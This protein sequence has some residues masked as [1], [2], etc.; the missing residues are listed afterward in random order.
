VRK[1]KKL[2]KRMAVPQ[3]PECAPQ[4]KKAEVF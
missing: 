4:A 2:R 1:E 3:P